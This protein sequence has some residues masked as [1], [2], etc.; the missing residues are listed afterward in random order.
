MF[1]MVKL[2]SNPHY[3]R[4]LLLRGWLVLAA[5]SAAP[6]PVSADLIV[7]AQSF[8]VGVAVDLVGVQPFDPAL[9]TLDRVLVD[10]QG[11]VEVRGIALSPTFSVGVSQNFMGLAGKY[12]KF[13]PDAQLLLTGS[14]PPGEPVALVTTF[15]YTFQFNE[16]TDLIGFTVP[17]VQGPFF[18]V[19]SIDGARAGFLRTPLPLDEIDVFQAPSFTAGIQLGTL[20]S[21]GSLEITYEFTPVAVPEPGSLALLVSGCL[22]ALTY[23]WRRRNQPESIHQRLPVFTL[24]EVGACIG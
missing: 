9:G 10:I 8:D 14:G 15:A 1:A 7:Q 4:R 24:K 21:Q 3:T 17:A 22:A 12:F 6:T 18:V 11:I 16:V 2:L 19:P 5:L 20:E 13:S 23:G